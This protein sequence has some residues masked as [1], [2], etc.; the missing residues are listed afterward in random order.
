MVKQRKIEEGKILTGFRSYIRTKRILIADENAT[1]R[2]NIARCLIEL[3]AIHNNIDICS[4]ANQAIEELK[5]HKHPVIVCEYD[6][7]NRCGLDLLLA[8]KELIQ[9]T[10]DS[11]FVLVTANT[12]QSAVAQAAE[13]DV[14]TY[15][16]KP[17]SSL[18]LRQRLLVAASEKLFPTEYM[19]RIMEGKE[20]LFE[21]K[22]Q[23]ALECFEEALELDESPT[24]A[25]FYIGQTNVLI[26]HMRQAESSYKQGLSLNRIHYKCL[27]GLFE[28]LMKQEQY[29]EAYDIVQRIA[30]YFPANPKRL[31][32][33][34]RLAILTKN[35]TDIERYYQT[36]VNL[37]QRNS[38]LIRYIC[39]GLIICG[40]FYLQ[41][42]Q[43]SRAVE[44]FRKA[45]VSSG[46]E[47]KLMKEVI[48][49]LFCYQ[50]YDQAVNFMREFPPESKDSE[51]YKVVEFINSSEIRRNPQ[52]IEMGK[53]LLKELSKP[54]VTICKII[55]LKMIEMS[56]MA[57]AEEFLNKTI[58]DHP[59]LEK[60]LRGFWRV[61]KLNSWEP[62]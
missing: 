11:L 1:A 27:V 2:T 28:L 12:S 46:R 10:K 19:Q 40:K 54:D 62:Y 5:R 17:F 60:E 48:A 37:D 15:I 36:F 47:P 9:D 16:I 52:V 35:Y 20:A 41:Q 14:D 13:E 29:Q 50:Q 58:K 59:E 61:R 42:K 4:T 38:E 3:G 34:L 8:Q 32:T 49:S 6:L 23:E 7:G 57:Q 24:L 22:L 55:L 30:N 56:N 53:T 25:Y 44:L 33:V 26:E 43:H 31:G 39:A 51:E 21:G 45:S 18:S